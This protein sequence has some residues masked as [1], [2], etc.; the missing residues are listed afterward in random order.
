MPL[1]HFVK[2]LNTTAVAAKVEV[3]IHGMTLS[4][5]ASDKKFM[6]WLQRKGKSRGTALI[7]AEGSAVVWDEAVT[8]TCTL[9][10]DAKGLFKRKRFAVVVIW[11]SCNQEAPG[12]QFGTVEVD[13]SH[14]SEMKS[15]GLTQCS[16]SRAL[17]RMSITTTYSNDKHNNSPAAKG[18]KSGGKKPPVGAFGG[19]AMRGKGDDS[20]FYTG[21]RDDD[22]RRG[23]SKKGDY[24]DHEDRD[25]YDEYNEY[26]RS[27]SPENYYSKYN[28]PGKRSDG[29]F[30]SAYGRGSGGGRSDYDDD[31]YRR[32]PDDTYDRDRRRS[33]SWDSRDRSPSY[34]DRGGERDRFDSMEREFEGDRDQEDEQGNSSWGVETEDIDRE[35]MGGSIPVIDDRY[36]S[37][38]VRNDMHHQYTPSLREGRDLGGKLMSPLGDAWA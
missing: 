17:I 22:R 20:G 37:P 21:H 38:S 25:M 19:A 30:E 26:R 23:E 34:D 36:A 28:T 5:D 1:G 11:N 33:G 35:F 15:Y 29:S 12:Q 2:T 10:Q 9:Y 3:K 31:Y 18:S 32:S 14:S 4:E 16:D 13:L 27:P 24:H 8:Q 6:V 7:K